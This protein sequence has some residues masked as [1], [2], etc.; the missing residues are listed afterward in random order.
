MPAPSPDLPLPQRILETYDA[1]TKAERRLADLLL[2]NV[3]ALILY[4]A[5]N[6]SE[7]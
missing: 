3:D 2:E 5:K 7:R 4:S 6:L 1:L